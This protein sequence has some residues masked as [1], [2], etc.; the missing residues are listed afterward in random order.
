[1]MLSV[2]QKCDLA[3]VNERLYNGRKVIVTIVVNQKDVVCPL[4][5]IMRYP[6]VDVNSLIFKHSAYGEKVRLPAVTTSWLCVWRTSACKTRSERQQRCTRKKPTC[7]V[8]GGFDSLVLKEVCLR[9]NVRGVYMYADRP[10][11]STF[12]IVNTNLPFHNTK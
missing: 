5:Q 7:H 6:L 12:H 4:K 2:D 8:R 9:Q 3:S 1:M 10:T 11:W